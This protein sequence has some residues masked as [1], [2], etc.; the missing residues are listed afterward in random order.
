MC[1]LCQSLSVCPYPLSPPPLPLNCWLLLHMLPIYHPG[2]YLGSAAAMLVL[3]SVS[4]ALGPSSLLRA[5]G[6]L[7][8]SWLAL[9]LVVGR[10]IPHRYV[11]R[12]VLKRW[13]GA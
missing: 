4:A 6:C 8:L 10:E 9:W 12:C 3:P 11:G 5:V 7:G 1:D 2:M 13:R